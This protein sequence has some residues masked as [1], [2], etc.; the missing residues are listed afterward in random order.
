[1]PWMLGDE[2]IALPRGNNAGELFNAGK[3]GIMGGQLKSAASIAEDIDFD[4]MPYPIV[5][6]GIDVPVAGGVSDNPA[7]LSDETYS[8]PSTTKWRDEAWEL[9]KW[10]LGDVGQWGYARSDMIFP[11]LKKVYQSEEYLN[12]PF[13]AN[14]RPL[15]RIWAVETYTNGWRV[16]TDNPMGSIYAATLCVNG[17][18]MDTGK[19]SVQEFL[20]DATAQANKVIGQY[21]WN[22]ALNEPGWRLPGVLTNTGYPT[23]IPSTS[24]YGIS[25][26]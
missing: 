12:Q 7:F 19:M 16:R 9:G 22:K 8:I 15:N 25:Y 14:G 11:A 6:R 18:L 13:L 5:K 3:L 1:M 17:S 4:F 10:F 21:K 26:R 2:P 24:P 23:G 20:D